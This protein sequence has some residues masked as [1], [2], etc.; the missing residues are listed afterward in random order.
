MKK[1]SLYIFLFLLENMNN[2]FSQTRS[3]LEARDIKY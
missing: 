1:L 3:G 2:K